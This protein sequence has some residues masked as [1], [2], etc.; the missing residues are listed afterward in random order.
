MNI[1][2]AEPACDLATIAALD[3][4]DGGDLLAD[5]ID[6]FSVEAPRQVEQLQRAIAEHET[7][8]A[9]RLAHTIK[10]SAGIFGAFRLEEM[11]AQAEQ[12]ARRHSLAQAAAVYRRLRDEIDRVIA[13]LA[14]YRA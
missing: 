3:D 8:V 12:A 10:G 6:T 2:E 14:R 1:D 7:V 11:A 13:A 5:L 9:A 4:E